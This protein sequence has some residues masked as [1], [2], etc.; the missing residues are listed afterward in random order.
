MGGLI[1][2]QVLTLYTTPVIYLFFDRLARKVKERRSR[3]SDRF[4]VSHGITMN[5]PGIFINRPVTTTLLTIGIALAGAIAFQLLPVAP[6]PQVDYP[7]IQVYANLPGADPE[8]MATS[9]AAPLERQFGSHR[10]RDGDDI[11]ELPGHN[12]RR[13]PV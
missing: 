6:L 1:I 2:S 11:N 13:A 12:N 7:T 4:R 10:G 8:T 5:I 3:K 9:V